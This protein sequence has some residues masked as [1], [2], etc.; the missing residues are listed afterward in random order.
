MLEKDFPGM[1]DESLGLS[2]FEE[3]PT[4]SVLTASDQV[5]DENKVLCG[6]GHLTLVYA[7]G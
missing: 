3:A 5:I 2:G 1:I 6:E 4:M 7:C